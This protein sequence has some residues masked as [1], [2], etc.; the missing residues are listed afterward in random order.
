MSLAQ[1]LGQ[2]FELHKA[3]AL[4]AEEFRAAKEAAMQRFTS[5]TTSTAPVPTAA[6]TSSPLHDEEAQPPVAASGRKDCSRPSEAHEA[7]ASLP[8]ASAPPPSS[9]GEGESGTAAPGN[10]A[11]AGR[12]AVP[13][14]PFTVTVVT[15]E[16]VPTAGAA[17]GE[18]SPSQLPPLSE[19]VE[20]AE[21]RFPHINV[22]VWCAEAAEQSSVAAR[23][24]AL[25]CLQR[26]F[27]N[28][29]TYP[30]EVKYRQLRLTNPTLQRDLFAVPGT[31]EL[32][33]SAGFA[34]VKGEEREK[35]DVN[36]QRTPNSVRDAHS[37]S[38]ASS[39]TPEA[40]TKLRL[41]S[42]AWLEEG[43]AAV[44]FLQEREMAYQRAQAELQR[45]RKSIVFDIRL[46]KARQALEQGE[47]AQYLVDV[48]SMDDAGDGLYTSR[49]HLGVVRQILHNMRRSPREPKYRQMRLQN[50]VVYRAVVQQRGGLEALMLLAGG[51]LYEDPVTQ[52]TLLRFAPAEEPA[53]SETALQSAVDTVAHVEAALEEI[54]RVREQEARKEA[55]AVMR[56]ERRRELHRELH[57]EDA[58]A[59]RSA[60]A[61]A[62][63]LAQRR[64]T[65]SDDGGSSSDEDNADEEGQKDATSAERRRI[66]IAEAL[67]ILMGK[68]K[69]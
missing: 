53:G 2:L 7:L 46:E 66:P 11:G 17:G 68:R 13:S 19:D 32:L 21:T 9:Q 57:R 60:D 23:A 45:L 56:E 1:E 48:F 65:S 33:E 42:T 37:S 61:N 24:T 54:Q 67:A 51:S 16:E 22:R 27:F 64:R 15:D 30:S 41:T 39:T 6:P 3:G 31:R 14:R 49:H 20:E 26:I 35:V 5:T 44:A 59:G 43:L 55:E 25:S 50:P 47:L 38:T 34:P 29:R 40:A 36:L 62:M 12:G 4:T 10:V 63:V 18:P 58:V 28:A 52:E 69:D 8:S